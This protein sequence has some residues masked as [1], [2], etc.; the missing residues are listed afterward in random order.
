[1]LRFQVSGF[2]VQVSGDGC[3]VPGFRCNK[4]G[5]FGKLERWNIGILETPNIPDGSDNLRR[6]I[7]FDGG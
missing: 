6:A 4:I 3:Q 7:E 2:S 5:K 1:M